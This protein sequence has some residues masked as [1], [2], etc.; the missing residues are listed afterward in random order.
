MI[1]FIGAGISMNF[2]LPITNKFVEKVRK[3]LQILEF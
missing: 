2:G 3:Y 1:I